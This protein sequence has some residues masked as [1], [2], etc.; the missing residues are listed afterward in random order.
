[1]VTAA[2]LPLSTTTGAVQQLGAT[3]DAIIVEARLT[4]LTANCPCC[5]VA[6]SRRQSAYSRTLADLPWQGIPVVV[7]LVVRRFWCDNPTCPRAIFAERVPDLAIPYARKTR[8]LLAVLTQ[9]GFALGG[10]G[11]RRWLTILGMPA[12]GATLLRLVRSTM[13]TSIATSAAIVIDD[14]ALRCGQRFRT[15]TTRTASG[16]VPPPRPRSPAGGTS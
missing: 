14:F 6:A 7:R 12:S 3:A 8:H 5:G 13:V 9:L 2:I 11:D 4:T 15:I 16:R 1:M 10:E